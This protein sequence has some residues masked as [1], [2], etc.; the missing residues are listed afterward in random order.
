[1]SY[2]VRIG[3]VPTQ[4]NVFDLILAYSRKRHFTVRLD[5]HAT[6]GV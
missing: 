4:I 5:H 6:L 1:M 3:G 2:S